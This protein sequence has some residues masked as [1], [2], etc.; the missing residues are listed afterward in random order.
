METL[1]STPR[2][3][4][5]SLESRAFPWLLQQ[6]AKTLGGLK[7]QN[8]ILSQFW[9]PQ[10]QNQGD[11]GGCAPL[12]GSRGE[13]LASSRFGWLQAPGIP[14]LV[15]AFLQSLLPSSHGLPPSPL[16]SLVRT[17]VVGFR[18][19]LDNPDDLFLTTL[20]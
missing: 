7:Q 15:A 3:F 20:I 18:A 9:R 12:G 10:L 1:R 2:L 11:C 4:L 6:T 19:R 5:D 13:P 16:L 14:W 17:L 8:C